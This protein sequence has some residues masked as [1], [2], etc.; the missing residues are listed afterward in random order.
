MANIGDQLL[1]PE[2]GWKRITETE[3]LDNSNHDSSWTIVDN[4]SYYNGKFL[5]CSADS[6]DL[7]FYIKSKNFRFISS[8]GVSRAS[9]CTILV[10]DVVY[11]ANLKNTTGYICLLFEQTGLNDVNKIVLCSGTN[12]TYKFV[13]DC[14]D[15]D[16]DGSLVTEA[17]YNPVRKFP[18]L[19]GDNTITSETNVA[20]YAK[21]LINGEKQLLISST[22]ESIYVTDGAGLYTKVASKGITS[23]EITDIE[24]NVTNA[25]TTNVKAD[26]FSKTDTQDYIDGKLSN[27]IDKID[28]YGLSENNFSTV[29][30]DKLDTFNTSSFVEDS[31]YVHTDNNFTNIYKMKVDSLTNDT[32]YVGMF[33]TLSDRDSYSGDLIVGLWCSIL[34]DTNYGSKKTKYIYNGTQWIYAGTYSDDTILIDDSAITETNITWSANKLTSELS[35]KSNKTEVD[36][37]FNVINT[38]LDKKLEVSNLKQGNN[39]SLDTDQYGNI[40][41]SSTGGTS[42]G[43]GSSNYEL[44]SNKPKINGITVIGNKTSE[45]LKLLSSSYAS[46]EIEGSVKYADKAKIVDVTGQLNGSMQYYGVGNGGTLSDTTLKMRPFPIGTVT[47]RIDTLTFDLLTKDVPQS[48]QFVREIQDINCFV[49][50]FKKEDDSIDKTDVFEDYTNELVGNHSDDVVCDTT[51]GLSI[52]D[53][54]KYSTTIN[55]DGMY[56]TDIININDFAEIIKIK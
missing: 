20:N 53:I 41:I 44:L 17:E 13:L 26:F 2:S 5:K 15:I 10:N 12:S 42:T 11:D 54:H 45:D 6:N 1:T 29:Y 34:V 28:G 7:T 19:I 14:I 47:D 39:I 51:N 56:E 37:T 49:Q 31:S 55:S 22:L 9:D 32:K 21:T 3:I 50:A 24:S 38:K 23:Q 36:T 40:T 18:V 30:K 43:T 16:L 27:K 25:V 4:S 52:N 8:G 33:D 46:T 48:I 35:L